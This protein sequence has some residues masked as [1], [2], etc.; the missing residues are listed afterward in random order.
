MNT[1]ASPA[2]PVTILISI[3]IRLFCPAPR[4]AFKPSTRQP[5]HKHWPSLHAAPSPFPIHHSKFAMRPCVIYSNRIETSVTPSRARKLVKSGDVLLSTVRP[6]RG[7]VGVV[8]PHQDASVCSTGLAVLRPTGIDPLTLASLLKTEFVIIQLLR[9][10]VG[11][12]Y[13]A[14]HESCL[15]SVLLPV[16]L[17]DLPKLQRQAGAIVEAQGHLYRIR[18][19]FNE[20]ICDA[21]L[22]WRQM[23]LMPGSK[24]HPT[25]QTISRR[26]SGKSDSDSHGPVFSSSRQAVPLD[27]VRHGAGECEI[28]NV[29]RA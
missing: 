11:I 21:G 14:I 1:P 27:V 26:R 12:A 4:R 24:P 13:P 2:S 18:S 28:A 29:A 5:P 8:G 3:L 20:S 25:S 19:V 22:A 15:P 10:N 7:A 9:N 16:R 17:A 6:E 23:S